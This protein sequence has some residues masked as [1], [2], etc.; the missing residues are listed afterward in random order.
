M[1][2]QAADPGALRVHAFSVAP[3]PRYF[4]PLIHL[5]RTGRIAHFGLHSLRLLAPWLKSLAQQHGMMQDRPIEPATWRDVLRGVGE[6]GQLLRSD[7]VVLAMEPYD[8]RV[9][10]FVPVVRALQARGVRVLY[11]TSWPFWDG[12]YQP[13]RSLPG[14]RRA[15]SLFLE[16]VNSVCVN[17]GALNAM[18]ARTRGAVRI[19]HPV[20]RAQFFAD[21][22]ATSATL[23]FGWITV[24]RL[25]PGKGL[26]ALI[27]VF[28]H[29]DPAQARLTIVGDGPLEQDLRDRAAG[30]AV[31]IRPFSGEALPGWL[32]QH[33][34]FVLN[35][36]RHGRWEELF[37]MTLIEAMACGLPVI[38]TDCSGPK[39][40]IVDGET[41][42]LIPQQDEVAL[43]RALRRI[44]GDSE[45][46]LG[47]RTRG[48]ELI[49]R[50]YDLE[51]IA[52]QWQAAVEGRAFAPPAAEASA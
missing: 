31:E 37:G 43:A 27:E 33:Q 45:L 18:Q 14:A 19:P 26:E 41:G 52:Q 11:H 16:T 23:P 51:R 32:R 3:S 6:L 24:A 39:E 49:D 36:H 13:R 42:V 44:E 34:G 17:Q 35:S 9:A 28:R 1:T 30:T 46:R 47:L 7:V 40:L 4:Q 38:A 2:R 21:E 48:L 25:A 5:Q 50:C 10:A 22:G 8:A 12:E 20:D 15:W 29:R